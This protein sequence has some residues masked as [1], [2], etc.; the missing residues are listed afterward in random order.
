VSNQFAAMPS[1]H[2]GWSLWAGITLF[3][4]SRRWWLRTLGLA[5]PCVTFFVI[6]G[7]ANHFVL[8]AAGGIVVLVLGFFTQRVLTGRPA[9]TP[10]AEF[11]A[12]AGTNPDS[13]ERLARTDS[14]RRAVIQ[15]PVEKEPVAD[16]PPGPPP[17]RPS[18]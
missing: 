2:I 8:D 17:P 15:L 14:H 11:V 18:G 6:I 13:V 4:L 12:V 1:L 5:Y 3:M 10:G 16:P 9:Y 7:T